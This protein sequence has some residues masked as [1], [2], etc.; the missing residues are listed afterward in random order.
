M[1]TASQCVKFR[2]EKSNKNAYISLKITGDIAILGTSLENK[3]C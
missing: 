3:I 2:I 1:H